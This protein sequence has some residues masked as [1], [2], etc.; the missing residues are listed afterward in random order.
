MAPN[1][2]PPNKSAPKTPPKPTR[3]ASPCALWPS[4][5][6]TKSPSSTPQRDNYYKLPRGGIDPGE[7]HATAI[8]RE[9]AEETG[10]V[11]KGIIHR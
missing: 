11:V 6:Q 5:R 9:F 10:G 3:T 4:T 8:H 2:P 7:D 1:Y